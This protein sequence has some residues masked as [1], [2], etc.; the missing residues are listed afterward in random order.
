MIEVR[1]CND[2]RSHDDGLCCW[3]EPLVQWLDPET[4][5]PWPSANGPL[6]VH[7]SAD[8]REVCE[9]LTGESL[10]K[11]KTWEMVEV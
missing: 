2:E 7:N 9:N 4:G 5:L 3:C 1:P 6:V 10:S 11:E 8:C